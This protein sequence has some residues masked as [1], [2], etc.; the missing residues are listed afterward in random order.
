MTVTGPMLT[1]SWN[2][3]ELGACTDCRRLWGLHRADE[4][5][6]EQVEEA[7]NFLMPSAG[8]CQ[9]MGTASTM[10]LMAEAIGMMLPGGATIPAVHADR[11]RHCEDSGTRAVELARLSIEAEAGGSQQAAAAIAPTQLMTQ[12]ALENALRVLLAVGGSTNGLV[13]IAAI[14]G[15]L[16][17]KVDL[18]QFDR[19][20]R[21]TPVLVDLKPTGV[22]RTRSLSAFFFDPHFVC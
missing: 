15:R 17:L 19:M 14:A 5:T 20:G 1:G 13:H 9:V 4:I 10:A 8:T 11:L 18:D 2:G 12:K 16:G 21:E 3:E 6:L 22:R 7:G